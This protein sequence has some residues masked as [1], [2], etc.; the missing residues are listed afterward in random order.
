MN[1]ENPQGS[2]PGDV[3]I[4]LLKSEPYD[5]NGRFAEIHSRDPGPGLKQP[6]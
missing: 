5:P 6:V 4:D 2:I 1:K 3:N